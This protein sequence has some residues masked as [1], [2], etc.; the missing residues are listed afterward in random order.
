M[1]RMLLRDEPG[2]AVTNL[3]LLTYAG[4]RE[5]LAEMEAQHGPGRDGRYRFCRGDINDTNLVYELLADCGACIHVAAESHV[6]R[7]IQDAQPFLRTNVQGTYSVLEA[8]RRH[9]EAGRR[10]RLVFVST[11]EVYGS[12]ELDEARVFAEEDRL[13]PRSPYAASKAAAEHL[14]MA[15]HHTFGSDVVITRCG[16]NFGPYQHEEKLI[17]KF[18]GCLLRGEP[19][20]LY[21]DGLHT[22]DW[23]HVEDHA[24]GLLA[25]L[26]RGTSGRAYNLGA[27]CEVSNLQL[28]R[29]LAKLLGRPER[30]ITPVADRP[31]H[32][33][34]YALNT[35]RAASELGW[36]ARRTDFSAELA[37][38]VEWYRHRAG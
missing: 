10:K 15:H 26:E 7:S 6:D 13:Q 23:I 2:P 11:D 8:L 1:V 30:L 36:R 9:A 33:R 18:I 27:G 31:G 3:D 24:Q 19:A 14:V 16:N 22:R 5:N 20:P 25:A 17:P 21:G 12:L 37:G 34:R 29:E 38:V 28:A 35:T 32:D 4:R